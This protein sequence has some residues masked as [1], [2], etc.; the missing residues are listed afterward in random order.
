VLALEPVHAPFAGRD[1][2]SRQPRP[3]RHDLT[4]ITKFVTK[5]RVELLYVN[6]GAGRRRHSAASGCGYEHDSSNPCRGQ[7]RTGG[8][9]ILDY[10][11]DA[12][13]RAVLVQARDRDLD[14]RIRPAGRRRQHL[15]GRLVSH[16]LLAGRAVGRRLVSYELTGY[17]P[18]TVPVRPLSGES[19]LFGSSGTATQFDPNPVF[20]A[21]QP[22]TPSKP[23]PPPK[24]RKRPATAAAPPP[25]SLAAP[26]PSLGGFAP[27]PGTFTPPPPM[28]R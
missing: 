20:A 6:T 19:G 2:W 26:P 21:L 3:R 13:L 24:K 8:L 11:V 12:E 16:S 28:I 9:F 10:I 17:L 14:D 27:P 4:R 5:F 22:A 18:Q 15:D 1:A 7:S 23:P 25:P